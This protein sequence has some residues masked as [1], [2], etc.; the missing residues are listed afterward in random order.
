MARVGTS[1]WVLEQIQFCGRF[2]RQKLVE[3]K[4]HQDKYRNRR[5]IRSEAGGIH[6]SDR[7]ER[8]K[9]NESQM[10]QRRFEPGLRVEEKPPE[11]HK[12]NGR[13]DNRKSD[14]EPIVPSD[15]PEKSMPQ[16]NVDGR[17]R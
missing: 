9:D 8:Q 7:Q 2:L 15:E 4:K 17:V 11:G 6:D 3:K 13:L 5:P 10:K 16:E 1:A 12:V 14:G